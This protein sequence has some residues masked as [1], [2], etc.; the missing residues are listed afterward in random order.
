MKYQQKDRGIVYVVCSTEGTVSQSE[1]NQSKLHTWSFLF[2]KL[3]PPPQ[4]LLHSGAFQNECSL[5]TEGVTGGQK[6]SLCRKEVVKTIF[7]SVSVSPVNR[8]QHHCHRN[9]V[10][11]FLVFQSSIGMEE[12]V[13]SLAKTE[14]QRRKQVK[15]VKIPKY[16]ITTQ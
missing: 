12:N 16:M 3:N 1:K 5:Y 2:F 4:R 11:I 8:Q 14:E 7:S 9:W 10:S 15:Q 6:P 13:V